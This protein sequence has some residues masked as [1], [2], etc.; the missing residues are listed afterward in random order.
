MSIVTLKQKTLNARRGA[1]KISGSAPGGHWLPQGPFGSNSSLALQQGID[2]WGPVGFSLNGGTRSISVGQDM[3]MS[4]SGTRFRGV[5]PY[6]YGGQQGRYD[7]STAPTMNANPT[8][9]ELRGNQYRYIKPSV[10]SNDGMIRQRYR[11]IRTGQYPWNVVQLLY[12]G[13]MVD[14]ASQGMYLHKL[15]IQNGSCQVDINDLAKYDQSNS[16]PKSDFECGLECRRAYHPGYT[17]YLRNPLDCSYQT[18]RIQQSCPSIVH[19]PGPK[20]TGTGI[21]HEGMHVGPIGN[22]SAFQ[23][24][25]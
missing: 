5:H 7:Q 17:K 12:T 25:A 11:W 9:M 19:E 3:K 18:E 16:N 20:N 15:R 1:T 22:S 14:N 24:C 21:L 10:L 8:K 6:G 23:A 2:V 4:Q 13:N